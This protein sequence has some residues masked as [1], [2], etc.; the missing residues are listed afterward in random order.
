[1]PLNAA[2][3]SAVWALKLLRVLFDTE[4][5]YYECCCSY[6]LLSAAARRVFFSSCLIALFDLDC[7]TFV[8]FCSY[9]AEFLCAAARRVLSQAVCSVRDI[10][11]FDVDLDRIRT[12]TIRDSEINL[13]F[14][15][16]LLVAKA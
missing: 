11:G 12:Y 9:F 16:R 4:L 1:M 7:T 6:E 15:K 8:H 2:A 14:E 10:L 13:A 3:T 5:S